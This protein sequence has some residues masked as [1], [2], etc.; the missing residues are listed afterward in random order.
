MIIDWTSVATNAA[1]SFAG[2]AAAAGIAWWLA[3]TTLKRSRTHQLM[4][5][6]GSERL[7]AARIDIDKLLTEYLKA[8]G[9]RNADAFLSH[10]TDAGKYMQFS[11]LVHFLDRASLMQSKSMLHKA[12][13]EIVLGRVMAH[14]KK[15]F[16]KIPCPSGSEWHN[17]FKSIQVDYLERISPC[18]TV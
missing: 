10:C 2:A 6:W 1:G 18:G 17:L 5:D 16:A 15:E 13:A 7:L 3:N 14:W 12:D 11:I 4:D 9:A 8:D